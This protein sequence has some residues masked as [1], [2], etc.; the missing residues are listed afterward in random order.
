MLVDNPAGLRM[1]LYGVLSLIKCGTTLS[2]EKVEQILS[3]GIASVLYHK[4][5]LHF[6]QNGFNPD[7]IEKIDAFYKNCYGVPDGRES[8]HA[9]KAN[10]GLYLIIKLALDNIC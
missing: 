8:L 2:C 5:S 4:Y 10:D 6:D 1:F 7:N 9:C 3:K